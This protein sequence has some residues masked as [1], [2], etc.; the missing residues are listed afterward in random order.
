MTTSSTS[1][2]LA[3]EPLATDP[4]RM[5][6]L[7]VGVDAGALVTP[8]ASLAIL[9]WHDRLVAMDVR[10]PW[11]RSMLLSV[12][13]APVTVTLGSSRS[14]LCTTRDAA[15]GVHSRLPRRA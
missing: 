12:V 11:G 15:R 7:L 3:L 9:L 2:Y 6:A 4:I 13:V 10:V 8:W 1:A 14:V 5:A